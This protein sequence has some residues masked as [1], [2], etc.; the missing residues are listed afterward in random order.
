MAPNIRPTG[1]EVFFDAADII[2]SKTDLKGRITYANDVFLAI[3][4]YSERELIGQPHSIIRHPDMPRAV[5]KLLWDTL[6][7]G[8]E[9]FAYVKNM[10]RSG[11]HY[12]VFAHATPSYDAAGRLVGYHSNRRVPKRSAV[13]AIAPIY[14]QLL[15]VEAEHRNGKESLA[16]ST[17]FL[18]DF[19]ASQKIGYDELVLAL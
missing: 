14:A 19:V 5:F 6:G 17:R 8:E 2:V 4:G 10:A 18:T 1:R 7:R 13:D 12:W 3:A 9:I 11:D 16:A 15:K